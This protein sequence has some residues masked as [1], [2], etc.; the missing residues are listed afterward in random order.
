MWLFSTM[1]GPV[2]LWLKCL[3]LDWGNPKTLTT[4]MDPQHRTTYGPVHGL[5]VQTPLMDHPPNRIKIINKHLSHWFSDSLLVQAN[6]Q[7]LHAL[8]KCNRIAFKLGCKLYQNDYT[9]PFSLSWPYSIRKE[10]RQASRKPPAG[11]LWKSLE[12]CALCPLPF[13]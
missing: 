13:C 12:I 1:G 6:I 3:P 7:M 10:D 2:A 4:V 5:P 8:C 11:S 9:L